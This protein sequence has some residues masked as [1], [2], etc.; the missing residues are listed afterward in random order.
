MF[1]TSRIM[2]VR[3]LSTQITR[4]LVGFGVAMASLVLGADVSRINDEHLQMGGL[5][6]R[7]QVRLMSHDG[8]PM[9]RNIG[10]RRHHDDAW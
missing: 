1:T 6:K 4:E 7:E 3:R 5:N 8:H 9:H 2:I 10:R